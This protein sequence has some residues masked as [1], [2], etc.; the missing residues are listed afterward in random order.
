MQRKHRLR[1][2]L[3]TFLNLDFHLTTFEMVNIPIT[4]I[5]IMM[6]GRWQV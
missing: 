3:S 4:D 1:S 2:R 5:D 6:F